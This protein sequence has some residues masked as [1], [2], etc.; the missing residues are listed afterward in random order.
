MR[1]LLTRRLVLRD[2]Q[3]VSYLDSGSGVKPAG[4]RSPDSDATIYG[5]FKCIPPTQ[6]DPTSVVLSLKYGGLLIKSAASRY[7]TPK[8]ER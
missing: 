2:S 8:G 5:M 3:V 1:Q 7:K 4:V 6:G